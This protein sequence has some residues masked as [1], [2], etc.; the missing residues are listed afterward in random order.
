MPEREI[1][2]SGDPGDRKDHF[3]P[4]LTIRDAFD[5]MERRLEAHSQKMRGETKI[6]SGP[7]QGV[8]VRKF[9]E[10]GFVRMSD[11][12]EIY[13]APNAVL[14]EGFGALSVGSPVELSVAEGEGA[15]GP[16]ASMVRPISEV[17]LESERREEI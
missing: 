15:M 17:S 3:D 2:I 1:V 5:A 8:V 6:L 4:N 9:D 12:Q 7:P 14:N 11:G 16:Q 10:Y 13:F